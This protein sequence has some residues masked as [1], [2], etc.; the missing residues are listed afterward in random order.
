MLRIARTFWW[1]PMPFIPK[2]I[3]V[4][5][6]SPS[7]LSGKEFLELGL[8]PL[9]TRP[10]QSRRFLVQISPC[11]CVVVVFPSSSIVPART[12]ALPSRST[13]LLT[14]VLQWPQNET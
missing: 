12:I 6:G 3:R 2:S 7:S 13:I 8:S 5:S 11:G 10:H 9:P 14:P 1:P 4:C